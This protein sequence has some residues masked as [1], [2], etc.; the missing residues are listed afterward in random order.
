MALVLPNAEDNPAFPAQAVTDKTDLAAGFGTPATGVISGGLV[1]PQGTPNMT[2]SV[3]AG[4][5]VYNGTQ[6]SSTAVSSLAIGAAS[7]GD[8]RDIVVVSTAG[9]VSVVAGTASTVAGWTTNSSANPPVK[10]A[11]PANAVL[12]GEVYVS[13]S[14]V[15]TSIAGGNIV[16]KT[17][18]VPNP[19]QPGVTLGVATMVSNTTITATA[20]AIPAL[21]VT[22]TPPT[23][24]GVDVTL[25]LPFIGKD[26]TAGYVFAN[27]LED[28]TIVQE[29]LLSFAASGWGF[30]HTL[31]N[32]TPSPNTAH[33]YSVQIAA[34]AGGGTCYG[35]STS[36][37]L[38]P[39]LEVKAA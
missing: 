31:I 39:T 17:S 9:V 13:A 33:T 21:A 36:P 8:R 30:L 26:A 34:S 20:T 32:R 15:T 27:V 4:S 16:D 18:I 6:F 28:G 35:Q 5:A 19:I 3:A 25:S 29:V 7:A 1:S 12:L 38:V 23:G 22:C 2:V 24:I 14:P 11:V 10:P 37:N